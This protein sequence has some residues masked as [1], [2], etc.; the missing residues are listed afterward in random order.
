MYSTNV[1]VL[2]M[3]WCSAVCASEMEIKSGQTAADR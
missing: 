3:V 1:N 2:T